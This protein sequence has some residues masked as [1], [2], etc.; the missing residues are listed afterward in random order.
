MHTNITGIKID[1][2]LLN[3]IPLLSIYHK[4]INVQSTMGDNYDRSNLNQLLSRYDYLNH[5][6]PVGRLDAD[7]S[8]L[9]LFSSNGHLTQTLLHPNSN[10]EREYEAIVAGIVDYEE[11]K[12]ILNNGVKTTEGIFP[13]KLIESKNLNQVSIYIH[14]LLLILLLILN[15][16][17]FYLDCF[18]CYP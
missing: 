16:L 5:M 1:G 6:H 10:I 9:L 12:E 17:F 2:V 7:T 15:M 18:C 11:L 3:E 14:L 4:P 8:G 13:A